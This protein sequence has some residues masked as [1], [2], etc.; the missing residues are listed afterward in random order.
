M[1]NFKYPVGNFISF[2]NLGNLNLNESNKL[3][4]KEIIGFLECEINCPN[5]IHPILQIRREVSPNNERTF[6]PI[7][8]FTGWFHSEEIKEALKLGYKIKII[9]GYLFESQDIF[10]N[11]IDDL[12][13]IKINADKNKDP[14]WRMISKLLMNSLYGRFG[15]DQYLLETSIINKNDK[16]LINYIEKT[17]IEDIIELDNK[18]LIQYLPKNYD[19][20]FF[21]ENLDV[22][23]SIA[24]A[25][26]VTAYSRILMYQYKNNLNY[27]LYYTDTD[28]LYLNFNS[29]EEKMK[30]E[31]NFVDPYKLGFFKS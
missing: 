1:K 25:S 23:I 29:I 24:I 2:Q 3:L 11:Y 13:E 20:L 14:I 10:N 22:N 4:N 5:I 16:T 30:F 17:N 21:Q 6:S 28:S 31:K 15:M 19:K 9:S 7:G 8:S 12:Y 27:K 26:S 18:L